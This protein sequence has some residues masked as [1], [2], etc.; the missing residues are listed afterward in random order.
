MKTTILCT[1]TAT[2]IAAVA[3]AQN[4]NVTW[5]AP[6][7]ITGASDVSTQGTFFGSWAPYDGNANTMPVNGVVFEGSVS[8]PGLSSSFPQ[9]DQSGYN[10]YNNPGTPSSSYNTLLQTAAYAGSGGGTIVLTWSD[11]PGHTYL[12]QA[13]ANDGRGNGRAETFTGGANTSAGLDFGDA[14]GAFITGTYVADSS[15]TETITLTGSGSNG[16]YPQINLLQIRDITSTTVTN[17]Q[18]AVLSA[19]PLGYWSL[20]LTD[21]NASSGIA[22][23]LTGNG[24]GGAYE[25]VST[26]G[27]LVAGPAP[28][29]TNAVSFTG[30]DYVYLGAGNNPN[31][32][33]FTGP[34]TLEAW[35]KPSSL[36][37]STLGD[38]VAKGYDGSY[39]DQEIALRQNESGTPYYGYFGTGGVSGGQQNTGW[40]YLVVANDGINDNLYING[41]LTATS[42]D[43]TGSISFSELVAWAIGNG[44]LDG[45]G[46]VFNGNICQVA[47]YN[48]G[49]SAAQI[50]N[51]YTEAELNTTPAAAKPIIVAQPQP[52]SGFVGGSVTFSV[53]AV[54][55]L[56]T[57]NQWYVGS[58]PLIGQTG[59]SLTLNNLQLTNAGNY[60]VVVGN[61]NGITNSVAAA[62]T[63]AIPNHLQWTPNG[64]NGQWDVDT[65]ANWLNLSNSTQ[66]VFNQGDNVLFD[67]T[68][69]VPTAV[70]VSGTVVPSLITVNSST[71][72]F[73][74][75][76]GTIS[77]SGSLLKL[78]TSP[79]SIS[80]SANFSGT[81]TIGG[82]SLYAGNNCLN[83]VFSIVVSNT[84]TL[85]F[86]GGQFS[87][88]KPVTVSGTGVNGEGALYNSY[89]D[90]PSELLNI[91]LAGDT[92]IG[93]TNRWDLL[94]GS[95]ISGAHN[96]TMDWSSDTDGRY[97]QW[98]SVTIGNVLGITVTNALATIGTNESLG[99]TGMDSAFRN[100]STVLTLCTNCQ[101][102]FYGGGF[103]GSLHLLSGA[104][105]GHYT[106]PAGFYGSTI[107]MENNSTFQSF[108]NTGETT[109]IDSAVTLNGVAHFI[110]GDHYMDYTNVISGPGGFVED[111]Y[112]NDMVFSSS[113][114]YTG[115]TII[116]SSG[117]SPVVALTGNG[118]ITHS[119]LIF[120]GG[121]DPTVLHLDASG[122]ADQTLALANGQTLG[123]AGGIKGN[124]VASGGAIVSPGGT[125][126]TIGITTGSNPVGTLAA[127]SNVTLGGTT[128][129]KLDGTTNDVIEAGTTLTYGGTLNLA[130]ISGSA[131]TAGNTFQIFNAGSYT[132][133]FATISPTTPGT[134]LTWN[135]SQLSSG[136]IS[137]SGT[138]GPLIGSTYI[139]GGKFIFNGTGGSGSGTYY[140]LTSTNLL[141]PLSGWTPI[142]TNMF[143]ANGTFS[144]TNGYTPGN[145]QQF[146]IIK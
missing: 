79:L 144:V 3:Q 95:Q 99:L 62:L 33:N 15:G 4:E 104:S 63:V 53:T 27:N 39:G 129:I 11:T 121:N 60:S 46:R 1:I 25:G 51:H 8:I 145:R 34:T 72:D 54:S 41:V 85:D 93:G 28:Y 47:I 126:T 91:T 14:P 74:I 101:L 65:S 7:A 146:Y 138:S 112:N 115:P 69:G 139:S 50:L 66:T 130:N 20:D 87:S 94:S 68:P 103:N 142:A 134:G 21:P 10:G 131:L 120:F 29:I 110:I 141:T 111:Y 17:Y 52:Q 61:V 136:I 2:L 35:A 31:Y 37:P 19:N 24:N 67:D 42:P 89:D 132:G 122:R 127:S 88:I 18:S 119:S 36:S 49:L 73:S 96:L 40:V 84:A 76:S 98:N 58:T 55:S 97:A 12:I 71:N 86:G 109:P 23:D 38:I 30:S 90:Y 123:G 44:T 16:D 140:V 117:N 137:V 26:S 56:S 75:S 118:S 77:G 108:Y 82:G 83:G 81:V 128:V 124:L 32:L 78:G 105:L 5:Q 116:G 45:N 59:T 100:P 143:N 125:N 6:T 22:T 135:T 48:Y 114:T 113:N 102:I 64:N 13:W 106:A 57:T 92:S 70:T 9:N 43:T 107:I 80:S 133:S